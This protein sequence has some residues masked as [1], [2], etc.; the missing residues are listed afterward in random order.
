MPLWTERADDSLTWPAGAAV[1]PS[2][3]WWL[4]L[5]FGWG[6]LPGSDI[7]ARGTGAWLSMCPRPSACADSE[8]TSQSKPEASAGRKLLTMGSARVLW[9]TS[10]PR[11]SV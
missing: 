7:T 10:S 3:S 9:L 5:G 4:N 2:V 6:S 11:H 8:H 1:C